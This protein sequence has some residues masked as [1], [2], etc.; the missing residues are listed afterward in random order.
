[1]N[2]LWHRYIHLKPHGD[3]LLTGS[4]SFWLLSA[5]ILV[6][7]TASAEAI[8]WGYVGTLFASGLERWIVGGVTFATIF[9]LVW[10]IDVSLLTF[11]RAWPEHSKSLLGQQPSRIRPL[12]TV[13]S[14]GVRIALLVGS[15]T[16]TAPYLSL[17][18]FHR[19]VDQTLAATATFAID[20][21]R[22][23]LV[24]ANQAETRQLRTAIE[25]KRRDFEQEVAGRG[26]S[27]RYGL[28]PAAE[29]LA[30]GIKSLEADLAAREK[31]RS[32]QLEL[33]DGLTADWPANRDRLA[34]LYGLALPEATLTERRRALAELLSKPENQS[35]ELAVKMYLVF[36]FGGLLLLKLFEPNSVRLYFSEILQQEFLRYL[37]GTFDSQLPVTESSR[38][39]RPIPPQRF[40]EFLRLTLGAERRAE[41][42][43]AVDRASS[44]VRENV[45]MVERIRQEAEEYLTRQR[46]YVAELAEGAD[47]A[48]RSQ[49]ELKTAAAAVRNDIEFFTSELEQ[50]EEP[51]SKMTERDRLQYR[52]HLTERLRSAIGKLRDLEEAGPSEAERCV[53]AQ[54]QLKRAQQELAQTEAEVSD[55]QRLLRKVRTTLATRA[56]ER[57][58]SASQ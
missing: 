27:G 45:E 35:V 25:M 24:D 53:R 52:S 28:G 38:N 34:S 6:L 31:D 39:A 50:C 47:D 30:T 26:Q 19:D 4:T 32:R 14:F 41:A 37:S 11:D 21:T 16:V 23:S 56:Q 40:F 58:R 44:A 51:S 1:M 20:R 13:S 57:I 49:Q 29:A 55:R 8:S 43:R 36:L 17:L 7:L 46:R 42:Q 48:L 5:R 2:N 22:T 54:V 33:F 3:H 9:A 18:V 15:L 12:K 10:A